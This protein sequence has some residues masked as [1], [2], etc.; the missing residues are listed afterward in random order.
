MTT[1]KVFVD[2][3]RP[4]MCLD[5]RFRIEN[6]CVLDGKLRYVSCDGSRP[7]WCALNFATVIKELEDE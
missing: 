4:E 6:T 2:I 1:Y 5:C 3:D 7:Y